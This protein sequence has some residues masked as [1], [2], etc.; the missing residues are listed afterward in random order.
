[1]VKK[2]VMRMTKIRACPRNEGMHMVILRISLLMTNTRGKNSFLFKKYYNHFIFVSQIEPKIIE[3]A[4]NDANWINAIQ[5]ELNK[6]E[7]NK[8]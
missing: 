2:K 3:E 8:V 7:R 5:E 1:M 6:F 4:E